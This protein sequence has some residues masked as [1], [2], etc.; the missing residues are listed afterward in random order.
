MQTP[1]FI[2]STGRCGSTM[3]SRMLA[4]H[5]DVASVSELFNGLYPWTFSRSRADGPN[6]WHVL[7][8]PRAH[9][10][11]TIKLLESGVAIDEFRYPL[12]RLARFREKGIPP[13][14]A[15]TL[16][17][18]T[19]DPD[20]LHEELRVF[21]EAL[22]L[23]NLGVQYCRI[24]EWLANRIGRKLWVERSGMSLSFLEPIMHFFPNAK[25]VHIWRDGRETALSASRFPP[26][27]LAM[28]SRV[29]QE[30][31]ALDLYRMLS[32]KDLQHVPEEFRPLLARDF[33]VEAFKRYAIPIEK[34]GAM[35][36]N[37]MVKG[38][39]LLTKLPP[40]RVMHL[41]Y[42]SI[43]Q[44]PDTELRR[45]IRFL[46]P[47]LEQDAWFEKVIPMVKNNP[48]KWTHLP[49]DELARL[50]AACAPGMAIAARL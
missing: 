26:M 10:K 34:F 11:L 23:D 17:E 31:T 7:S 12:S 38:I 20:G 46:D 43:L 33:D 49:P 39:P 48:V 21:V 9:S 36:S 5:P 18:L 3:L 13:M 24:F 29:L 45:F 25:F 47:S 41:R 42:E 30:K 2:V 35:W 8:E 15:M 28:I 22:P 50:E 27:R 32:A 19:E 1:L 37:Q 40:E 14:L 16:P 6:L 44:N 4:H